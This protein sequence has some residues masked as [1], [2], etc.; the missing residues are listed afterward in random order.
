MKYVCFLCLAVTTIY[1]CGSD[2]VISITEEV[3]ILLSKPNILLMIADDMGLDAT[4]GYN[5][6][7]VKPY[8]PNLESLKDQGIQFTNLWSLP[9]CTPTRA[10]ILTGKYGFRT[11]VT[12]V[13]QELSTNEISIHRYL[14]DINSGYSHTVIGKW[15]LSRTLSHPNSMGIADYSG[16]VSGGLSSYFDWSLVENGSLSNT[17][18]Y[19]TTKFTDLA[20]Q[21]IEKQND[22]WFLWLAYNAPHTPFHLPPNNL[23]HQGLLPTDASSISTNPRPYYLAMLEAM[24][25]EIGRLLGAMSQEERA[26]TVVIFV[27]DN[28]TPNQVVQTY[29]ERKAKGSLYQGG[30]N[31]PMIISGKDVNRKGN[32]ED[33]L[34]VTT[35]LFATIA[36]IAGAAITEIHD[37]KSFKTLFDSE[38]VSVRDYAYSEIGDAINSLDLTIRNNDYKLIKFNNGNEELYNLSEDPLESTNLLRANR[39]PLSE[40]ALL[41]KQQLE[42]ELT[43]IK[44]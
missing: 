37:S 4:P 42:A 12:N 32:Q 9:L 33:A 24:D 27:G 11:Q 16:F 26:N 2:P 15:H 23:H 31:V 10:S 14:D 3:P 44:Q 36:S 30:I 19:S 38:D 13:G 1:S 8:M 6:G 5:I 22:P 20:I 39:L 29:P 40:E 21:W 7:S 18:T 35:D 34:L 41:S 28:G 17:S 43:R 25:T